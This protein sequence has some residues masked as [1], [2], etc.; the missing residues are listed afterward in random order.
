MKIHGV[1]TLKFMSFLAKKA[2]KIHIMCKETLN[3]A[4]LKGYENKTVL[5]PMCDYIG[6]YGSKGIN[7][8]ERYEID[9]NKKI[10]LFSG[11][12]RKYKNIELLINAFT[13][14]NLKESNF[15][16]LICGLCTDEQYKK[17]LEK[18][19]KIPNVK[20]DFSFIEDEEMGDYLEQSEI[21]ISPYNK[22]SSL[23]SGALIMAMS[24]KRSFICPL[25]GTA[26][27]IRD[28]D[29]ILY[30]YDYENDDEHFEKLIDTLNK[31]EKD[32]RN[33]ENILKEKGKLAYEYI[34]NN[35][36]WQGRKM[37]WI[38]LYKF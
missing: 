1:N 17:E 37:D 33:D 11:M 35:Q 22:K 34:K 18:I 15:I 12:I 27:E 10:I 19:S 13:K 36:T 4:Y 23:N 29:K 2:D 16:L 8:K 24:Y 5:I 28:Y 38:N 7:I 21:L 9:E 14:S 20:F 25:I 26:K 3:N 32:V 31:L 6:N 30:T